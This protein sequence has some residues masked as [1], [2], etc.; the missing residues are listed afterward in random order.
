MGE[1][2]VLGQV[3]CR[4]FASFQLRLLLL[5]QVEAVREVEVFANVGSC[6]FAS[7]ELLILTLEEVGSEAGSDLED[8]SKLECTALIGL[9]GILTDVNAVVGTMRK[10]I[11]GGLV[12][13]SG[14]T[15][16]GAGNGNGQSGDSESCKS[17]NGG[18]THFKKTN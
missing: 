3:S 14:D 18:G 11:G 6:G 13:P 9:S 2:K 8:L 5:T 10:N 7:L 15:D 17:D 16:V 4:G 12:D 1:V